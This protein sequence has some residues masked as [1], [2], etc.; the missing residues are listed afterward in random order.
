MNIIIAGVM[1]CGTTSMREYLCMHPGIDRPRKNEFDFFTSFYDQHEL[2]WY[3]AQLHKG[4]LDKSPNYIADP[5]VP[6][7]IAKDVPDAKVIVL[8]RNPVAR[9]WSHYRWVLSVGGVRRG[10]FMEVADYTQRKSGWYS[11]LRRGH[12]YEQLSHWFEIIPR[13]QIKIVISERLWK[14]PQVIYD[15]IIEFLGLSRVPL[16]KPL[17][18]GQVRVHGDPTPDVTNYLKNY[19]S[20]HNENLQKLLSL[21][22]EA[23]WG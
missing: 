14:K 5:L 6:A 21:D 20:P 1:R 13:E 19:Y 16:V 10:G 22:L 2:S 11:I 17:R 18:H 4:G 9:A 8:L 15:E 12:Y 23:L 7:R 3:E